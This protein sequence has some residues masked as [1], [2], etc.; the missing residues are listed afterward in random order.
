MLFRSIVAIGAL[1]H[2]GDLRQAIAQCHRLLRSGGRLIFMVYYAYSY[3][4]FLQVPRA[5]ITYLVREQLGF[6]G[7]VGL[8]TERERAA[9][10]AGSSGEGA[11]HTDWISVRSLKHYCEMFSSFSS[12]LEN[13]DQE[14][15]FR[16]TSRQE[17]GRAHV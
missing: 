3:R 4:R 14:P 9:Y 13:I 2:T 17:I 10:D 7:C 1:H 16:H 5:T 15:P 12:K 8:S 11:P 6:R